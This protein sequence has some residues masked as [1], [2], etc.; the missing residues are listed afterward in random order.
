[1]SPQ[2]VPLLNGGLEHDASAPSSRALQ[3]KT[4][5][6]LQRSYSRDPNSPKVRV[7][8]V[9]LTQAAAQAIVDQLPGSWW[10]R[11]L[12]NKSPTIS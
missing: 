7:V 4:Y 1:M 12:A 6:V 11:K 5:V 8:D 9:K 3:I 2:G 10:V